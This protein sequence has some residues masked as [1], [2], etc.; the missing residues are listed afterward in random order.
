MIIR[1]QYI[2]HSGT[3]MTCPFEVG[4]VG[5]VSDIP[6]QS[7]LQLPGIRSDIALLST[8]FA[9]EHATGAYLRT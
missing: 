3:G 6:P 1:H 8:S 5:N 4:Q 9:E 7:K 2:P